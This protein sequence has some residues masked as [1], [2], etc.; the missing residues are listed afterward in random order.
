MEY[1]KIVILLKLGSDIMSSE[2]CP[3]CRNIASMIKTTFENFEENSEGKKVKIVT[4][5]FHCSCC[6][7]FVRSE[8]QKILI[9]DEKI[10]C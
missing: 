2:L 7:N 6:N 4:T 8:E 9:T 3:N 10:L 5:N 1:G